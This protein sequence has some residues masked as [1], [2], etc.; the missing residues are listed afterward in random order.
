MNML[1]HHRT[2]MLYNVSVCVIWL[3]G[4]ERRPFVLLVN[5]IFIWALYVNPNQIN[6]RKTKKKRYQFPFSLIVCYLIFFSFFR[7]CSEKKTKRHTQ[8][9]THTKVSEY[10]FCHTDP[11]DTTHKVM[12]RSEN[13]F[14]I[15]IIRTAIYTPK[16]RV[17]QFEK[18]KTVSGSRICKT[19]RAKMSS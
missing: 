10:Y 11:T 7:C 3:I 12:S 19:K 5:V 13:F 8:A 15:P 2:M 4:L 16:R 17:P 18:L 1:S 14:W 6:K 9:H